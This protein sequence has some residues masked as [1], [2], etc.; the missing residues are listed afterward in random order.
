[1]SS[2]DAART[3]ARALFDL[4]VLSDSVDATDEGLETALSAVR[5][6]AGLRDT[7]SEPTVSEEKKREILREVFAEE[8]AAEVL[9]AVTL[10]VDTGKLELLEDVKREFREISERERGML[11][12][13]VTTAV[14][15]DD[16]LR[17]SLS[18]RLE[19]A[20]GRP[21]TLR[22][23]VDPSIVGGIVINVAG[24]VLDG[25]VALQLGEARA[26]LARTESG[27]GTQGD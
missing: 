11:V 24:K 1:M 25:S 23:R 4:A 17:A 18:Q 15:L 19:S 16:R 14:A 22:E 12:A 13:D 26:A 6:H 5:G 21:V 27:G 8:V 20:L 3:H 10:L 2:S 7:L 9:S